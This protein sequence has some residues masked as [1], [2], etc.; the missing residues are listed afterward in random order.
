MGIHTKENEIFVFIL[1]PFE[2]NFEN[3]ENKDL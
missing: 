3:A 1:F 2:I